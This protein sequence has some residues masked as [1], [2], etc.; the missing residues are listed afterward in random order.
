MDGRG[1]LSWGGIVAGLIILA[2]ASA[3]GRWLFVGLC[4]ALGVAVVVIEVWRA[5]R[6]ARF[7]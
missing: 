2:L 6:R 7:R 4:L 5:K 3:E 1:L